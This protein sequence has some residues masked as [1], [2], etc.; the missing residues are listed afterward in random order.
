MWQRFTERARRVILLG[1]QEAGE[2]Q[3]GHVGAEHLLL[4]LLSESE[5][6]ASQVLQEL[7]VS[8]EETREKI[9]A[10]IVVT[11]G[12]NEPKLTRAAK[13][14]LELAGDEARQMRHNYIGTEHLL[15]ALLR[16]PS[17]GAANLLEIDLEEAR[18]EMMEYLGTEGSTRKGR[19]DEEV[20]TRRQGAGGFDKNPAVLEHIA[21]LTKE[22]RSLQQEV[23]IK[24]RENLMLRE[25]IE[26]LR[27]KVAA[28]STRESKSQDDEIRELRDEVAT[29]KVDVRALYDKIAELENQNRAPEENA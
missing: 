16:E 22:N 4:G 5:G 24:D 9:R 29:L 11:P 2:M 17:G 23:S 28:A 13:H 19:P 12:D 15:L 21:E 25:R 1:Q 26:M 20:R 10:Q 8:L 27:E 3:S 6:V 18:V 14:V 7:D